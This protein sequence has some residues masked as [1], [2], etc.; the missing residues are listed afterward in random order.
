MKINFREYKEEDYEQCEELVNQ[1]W[2]FEEIFAPKAVSD[3]ANRIYTKGSVV[4]SNYQIVAE[5]NGVVA[6]F[7][8]G[9][10]ENAQKPHGS[11]VFGLGILWQLIW[12]KS[13]KPKEKKRINQRN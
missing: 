1:A 13:E 3:I 12:L 8:F 6:G 5:I 7:I 10:N 2:A 11:L 4:G 9:L